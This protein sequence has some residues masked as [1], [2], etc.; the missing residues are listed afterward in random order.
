VLLGKMG[1]LFGVRPSELLGIEGTH[2]KLSV[3]IGC[4]AA[5]WADENKAYEESKKQAGKE[6]VAIG[7][8]LN[9]YRE[10]LNSR[11]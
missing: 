6:T 10:A 11:G 9:A 5:Y 2:L 1:K 8:S 7:S 4:A 3:D